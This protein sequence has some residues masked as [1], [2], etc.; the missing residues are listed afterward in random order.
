MTPLFKHTLQPGEVALA[1]KTVHLV[2][3]GADVAAGGLPA[4]AVQP[5]LAVATGQG[6][7]EPHPPSACWPPGSLARAQRHA[8][9]APA[10]C[11]LRQATSRG[12][13]P[14]EMAAASIWQQQEG[15]RGR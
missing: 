12:R 6:F 15:G 1:L 13:D 5:L 3:S 9:D 11:C 4:G 2:S 8:A 10:L 14:A 7:G